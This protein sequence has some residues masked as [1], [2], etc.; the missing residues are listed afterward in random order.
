MKSSTTFIS[1]TITINTPVLTVTFSKEDIEA[2]L[3]IG[4]T[5]HN[6]RKE[7]FEQQFSRYP[8]TLN[9]TLTNHLAD[10]LGDLYFAAADFKRNNSK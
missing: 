9:E 2:I 8:E 5:S 3:L 6:S 10:M 4:M 1:E 7:F